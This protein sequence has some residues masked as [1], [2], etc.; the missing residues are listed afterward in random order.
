MLQFS[1]FRI[2]KPVLLS[3]AILGFVLFSVEAS[4]QIENEKVEEIV[5][6]NND[7]VIL[8]DHTSLQDNSNSRFAPIKS[9]TTTKAAST[10]AKKEQSAGEIISEK[11]PRKSESPS[12]LSFNIFLYIVDKFKAD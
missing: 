5:P 1:G 7:R 2:K 9:S 11:D 6:K 8:E 12:T 3:A 10:P 4:A